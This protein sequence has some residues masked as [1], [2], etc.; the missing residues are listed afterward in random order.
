MVFCCYF[1]LHL[2]TCVFEVHF[3]V[4]LLVVDIILQVHTVTALPWLSIFDISDQYLIGCFQLYLLS[5]LLMFRTW[6]WEQ[7]SLFRIVMLSSVQCNSFL[8]FVWF[9]L[10]VSGL[11]PCYITGTV[12]S[13][14]R[15]ESLLGAAILLL[16]LA[17]WI[18][19]YSLGLVRNTVAFC[20]RFSR[21][22]W[23][24]MLCQGKVT[25]RG[26]TY[27]IFRRTGK[28]YAQFDLF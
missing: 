9:L 24:T 8:V 17:P 25:G 5:F 1:Y 3:S 28:W 14:L 26:Q 15:C 27:F 16:L 13:T 18:S 10:R 20:C 4:K 7:N 19:H 22:S 6:Y 23:H 12:F 21:W 2:H 11:G